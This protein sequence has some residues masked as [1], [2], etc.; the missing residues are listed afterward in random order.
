MMANR[1]QGKV[2][3]DWKAPKEMLYRQ[4][5]LAQ[6]N[7]EPSPLLLRKFNATVLFWTFSFGN[8]MIKLQ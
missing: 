8:T 6:G 3:D 4:F 1:K 5:D 7:E 2:D